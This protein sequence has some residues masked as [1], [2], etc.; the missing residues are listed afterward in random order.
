[1]TSPIFAAAAPSKCG[2]AAGRLARATS[3]RG[4]IEDLVQPAPVHEAAV[5]AL[6]P[7][8]PGVPQGPY[9]RAGQPCTVCHSGQGPA[10]T[11]FSLAG[12]VFSAPFTASSDA[13]A[14]GVDQATVGVVDDD[15]SEH[16][17]LTNCVGNFY[18][19]P[20][21]YSPAFPILVNVSKEGAGVVPMMGHIG[22]EASCAECHT[23][24]SGTTSPGRVFL[25][26]PASANDA[27]C[28]VSPVMGK[29]R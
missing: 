20:D 21:A 17:I 8:Q 24:P 18:V 23:D 14:V 13:G 4:Q 6:G 15:G 19:T 1:M 26:T 22:R 9:H 10:H 5:Q 28:P 25:P 27:S 3:G 16:S 11:V 7:E 29:G 12:T 2:G